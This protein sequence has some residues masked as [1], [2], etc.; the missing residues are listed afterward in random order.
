MIEHHTFYKSFMMTPEEAVSA[1]LLSAE[2]FAKLQTMLVASLEGIRSLNLGNSRDEREQQLLILSKL[3]G[4]CDLLTEL[5]EQ[6]V[7]A[8]SQIS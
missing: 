1:N 4:R 8:H 7:E 5:L 2:T 3:Q 6:A